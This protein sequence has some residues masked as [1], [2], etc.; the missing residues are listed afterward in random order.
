MNPRHFTV[1]SA[2]IFSVLAACHSSERGTGPYQSESLH[3]STAAPLNHVRAAHAVVVARGSVFAIAGTGDVSGKPVLEVERF[4]G[5]RWRDETLLPGDGL[6]APAAVAI[7]DQI[8]VLGG[9]TTTTNIPTDEVRIYDV[10]TREWSR[11]PSLPEPRGGHA[12][13]V[14]DGR[15]H[16]IGGGNSRSTL[17]L[18][19][20]LDPRSGTWV[21]RAPL[22]RAMG[23]PAAV[24]C[25]GKL[26]CIGGRSGGRDFGD[27]FIY[28]DVADVWRTGPALV[29]R[30]TSG[31]AAFNGFIF[32]IGGES[33]G[34]N[35]VLDDVLVLA[36][37]SDSWRAGPSMPTP[38]SF[39]RTVV[40]RNSMYVVGGSSEPQT[41]HAPLG[42]P[43]VERLSPSH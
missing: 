25:N 15:I 23:S 31:A 24:V 21:E 38:R 32:V 33:Q 19:S 11:G 43:V 34:E 37:G 22:P 10:G 3:W 40:Y 35:R 16:V 7:D 4:N 2:L 42:T 29:P 12:A 6:N 39:A 20:V 5:V 1:A 27:V 13:A 26:Y 41:S 14:L 17:A 28:D 30:G 36:P 9:F 8:Y 18:H